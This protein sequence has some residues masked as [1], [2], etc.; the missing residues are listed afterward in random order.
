M[1]ILR[2]T[3]WYLKFYFWE[4]LSINLNLFELQ[5]FL[6]RNTKSAFPLPARVLCSIRLEQN[7]PVECNNLIRH[8]VLETGIDKVADISI[9]SKHS[10][11]AAG[12]AAAS[13]SIKK[14]SF[15]LVKVSKVLKC[16]MSPKFKATEG[17]CAIKRSLMFLLKST[18][19]SKRKWTRLWF[20]PVEI[21][22]FCGRLSD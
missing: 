18:I 5:A 10:Q 6:T 11:R 22:V 8:V 3:S 2:I 21:S 12:M 7:L 9:C 19:W 14:P 20:C 16:E 1:R 15:H 4:K 17:L 13:F